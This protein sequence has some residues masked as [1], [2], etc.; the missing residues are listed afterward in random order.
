[1]RKFLTD[2]KEAI[3]KYTSIGSLV[4]G[5]F[6]IVYYSVRLWNNDYRFWGTLTSDNIATTGQVG[7]FIGGV[8]GA[9]WALT[10]VLLFYRALTL[11]RQELENQILELRETREVFRTQQ[12]ENIFFNLIRTQQ[13]ITNQTEF[14]IS[15]HINVG[16]PTAAIVPKTVKGREFIM[17]CK[18][19]YEKEYPKHLNGTP[20]E[21]IKSSYKV[22]FDKNH[23]QLGHYFR[24]LYHILKFINSNEEIEL[25]EL[26]KLKL[27]EAEL[28]IR[29]TEVAKKYQTYAGFIQAQMSSS[30]LFLLFYNG[31]CFPEMK[32]QIIK[33]NQLENLAVEDLI[34]RTN[35]QG[36]YD[37]VTLKSRANIVN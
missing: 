18:T 31:L 5:L 3:L 10:G 8:V 25:N 22:F 16:T 14:E 1:M 15:Q 36:L 21:K 32:K 34:D 37:G 12:F 23:N 29:K 6:L 30:E 4:I 35:H 26:D 28:V 13:E 7:D 20:I 17:I 27:K 19:A 2:N 24:H 9:I 33:Y 11:Q